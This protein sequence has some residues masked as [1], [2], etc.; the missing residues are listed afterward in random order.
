MPEIR[1]ANTYFEAE[2]ESPSMLSLEKSFGAHPVYLQL[3]FLPFLYSDPDDIVMLTHLPDPEYIDR[4]KQ[5]GIRTPKI[6]LYTANEPL[7]H[8]PIDCW[9]FTPAVQK[10]AKEHHLSF[11]MPDWNCVKEVNSKEFSFTRSPKLPG[12]MLLRNEIET[13]AWIASTT[14]PRVFKSVYG[15]SGRGHFHVQ[16]SLDA[17][18][19]R[20]LQGEWRKGHPVI[21]EVW[22]ERVLDFSTQ[23][24]ISKEKAISYLG[25][26][27]CQN[28][29]K[30]AYKQTLIPPDNHLGEAYDSFLTLHKDTALEII[31]IMKQKGYYGH[32]GVDAMLYRMHGAL[33][34]HPIVEINARKTMGWV[35][36]NMQRNY[37]ASDTI[38]VRYSSN[39]K[40]S[41][42]LPNFAVSA[43]GKKIIFS[44][45]LQ[46]EVLPKNKTWK[47][48]YF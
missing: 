10:W 44:K 27:L 26:T 37:H 20:F 32:V 18:A 23:W 40:D 1:I 9:G 14:G 11:S 15:L 21:A 16:E 33:H 3:Q 39:V 24:I 8:Y 47:D 42:L 45:A 25:V 41:N 43:S 38:S 2:M 29:S 12:S 36:L 22:V 30:G 34:L 4:L 46:L 6:H 17:R 48:V 5:R 7:P 19:L 28:D 13:R 31:H 35:A